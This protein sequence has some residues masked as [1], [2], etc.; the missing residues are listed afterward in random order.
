MNSTLRALRAAT[1]MFLVVLATACGGH[2][3]GAGDTGSNGGTGGTAGTGG[4]GGGGGSSP[5]PAAV[6]NVIVTPAS[7]LL[8]PGGTAQLSARAVDASGATVSNVTVTWAAS[9]GAVS[10]GQ[11]G[12]VTAGT[13]VDSAVVTATVASVTSAPV[14]ALV[15]TLNPGTQ[16][17]QDGQVVSDPALVDTTEE[18]GVGSQLK[19]TLSGSTAPATGTIIV[20]SGDKPISGKVVSTAVNGANTDVVFQVLPL[21]DVFS[22]LKLNQTYAKSE[23]RQ[24]FDVQPSQT[25]TRTDGAREYEFTL[26]TPDPTASSPPRVRRAVAASG[27]TADANAP[28]QKVTVG[29]TTWKVG[30][31]SCK[32]KAD[33]SAAISFRNM[34]PH[35]I[36][37]MGPV[38]AAISFGQGKFDVNL[39]A[40]GSMKLVVDGEIHLNDKLT[41]SVSCDASL[42]KYYVPVPP[43]LAIVFIPVVPVVGLRASVSGTLAVGDA[44]IGVKSEVEQPLTVGLTIDNTGTFTNTSSLDG[45]ATTKFDWTLGATNP[46]DTVRFS[47]DAKAGLYVQASFT[48]AALQLYTLIN[49]SYDPIKSLLD[50]F[51]GFHATVGLATVNEQVQDPTVVT[52]YVLT[53]L[54]QIKAGDFIDTFVSLLS[55]V[56]KLGN[57]VL[58]DLKYEPTLFTHPT[59]NAR[60]SLRRFVSG[61]TIQF[62]VILDPATVD[63]TILGTAVIGYN[64]QQVQIWRKTSGGQSQMIGMDAGVAGAGG[65]PGKSV[66]NVLWKADSD[67]TTADTSSGTAPANFYAVVVPNFGDDF[68]FRVGPALGWLGVA[69]LGG[70]NN[71]EGTL[72]AVDPDG[73]VLL[74]VVAGSP[75]ASENRPSIGGS[76]EIQLLKLDPYGTVIWAR[77]IDGPGDEYVYSLVV[78]PQGIIFISGDALNSSVTGGTV[79]A[80]GF[81]TWAASYSPSG[82]QLWLKQWQDA[83]FEAGGYVALGPNRELY[84]LGTTSEATAE[85]GGNLREFLCSETETVAGDDNRDCGDLI[86]RQLNPGNGAV[87]WTQVDKRAGWQYAR[88][89]SADSGGNLYTTAVTFVDTDTQNTGQSDNPGFD[90]FNNRYHEASGLNV[91]EHR[92]VGLAMSDSSGNVLWRKT[93]KNDRQSAPGGGFVYSEEAP[94]G[95]VLNAAGLWAVIGTTGAFPDTTPG[96]DWDAA[97]FSINPQG[98]DQTLVRLYA[99]PG[100]DQLFLSGPSP[101]GGLLITGHTTGSLFSPSVGGQDVVAISL[102]ADG[103]PRWAEQFGGPGNDYGSSAAAARD[104][105]IYITGYTDGLMPATLSG[106]PASNRLNTPAGAE[107]LF[108]AKL[109]PSK[110]TIQVAPRQTIH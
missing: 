5:P 46:G 38:S 84:L 44:I 9:S 87:L 29:S 8:Q 24:S 15:A 6:A 63:P 104:G 94:G 18:P 33:L 78:D 93:V 91:I 3:T 92:G 28:R 89:L 88:G 34:T 1:L 40:K 55:S 13:A 54:A 14:T 17:I 107:D 65:A 85:L 32:A 30:P 4:T 53:G 96:G 69:Q 95:I 16:V 109:G 110:G 37:N 68:S 100:S 35:V 101:D 31:F 76:D 57:I 52:G 49:A 67:G 21:G 12:K 23:L 22:E 75:L 71:D 79:G 39:S 58:P 47:G 48:N 106:L 26:D 97:L 7:I 42:F 80:D 59:G 10:I 73:N 72:T 81:S 86:L 102:A 64:V 45:D 83:A 103:S 27:K 50:A 82:N 99:S 36:D 60:V 90:D 108:V 41:D 43:V 66:F 20:G 61:E 77:N 62:Q 74:A 2:H 51:A 70:P 19:M 11:D 56:L 98:G 105:S 25:I